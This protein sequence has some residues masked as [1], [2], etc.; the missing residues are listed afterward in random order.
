MGKEL[1]EPCPPTVFPHHSPALPLP[2]TLVEARKAACTVGLATFP[3]AKPP[4]SPPPHSR[5]RA[6]LPGASAR[7]VRHMK[8][9]YRPRRAPPPPVARRVR[10]TRPLEQESPGTCASAALLVVPSPT[11]RP[12]QGYFGGDC[13]Q[14]ICPKGPWTDIAYN[15]D[16]AHG[17][18]EC[19]SQGA[20]G[21]ST[22]QCRLSGFEGIACT[23]ME[24][25]NDCNGHGQC[26]TMR[27]HSD[28]P[29]EGLRPDDCPGVRLSRVVRL[30]RLPHFLPPPTTCR[31][32]PPF[33]AVSET[34]SPK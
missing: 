8:Q 4:P 27:Q 13:S 10:A 25:P 29:C 34:P 28:R 30:P 3:A 18:A 23:R 7:I 6:P 33:R 26:R 21:R 24:C 1:G 16:E 14:R 19:S 9:K 12:S 2:A 11:C 20:L 5:M 17:M 15:T 32:S 22:G 31:P